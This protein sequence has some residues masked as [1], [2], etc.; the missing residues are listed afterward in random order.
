MPTIKYNKMFNLQAVMSSDLRI[1]WDTT[2]IQSY[3]LI[4]SSAAQCKKKNLS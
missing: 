3:D 1:G 4:L 2:Q